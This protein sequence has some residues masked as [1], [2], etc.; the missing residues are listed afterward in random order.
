[1][2]YENASAAPSTHQRHRRPGNAKSAQEREATQSLREGSRFWRAPNL[3]SL[4]A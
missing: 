1:M 4:E 2:R 3:K